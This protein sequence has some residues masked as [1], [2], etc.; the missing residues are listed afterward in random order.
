[1][2]IPAG[3]VLVALPARLIVF[4]VP[5]FVILAGIISVLDDAIPVDSARESCRQEVGFPLA[6]F[7]SPPSLKIDVLVKLNVP[8]QLFQARPLRSIP[9]SSSALAF[10][11]TG[12]VGEGFEEKEGEEPSP[13]PGNLNEGVIDEG[14][15]WSP[16]P[17]SFCPS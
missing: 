8:A 15:G 14:E 13:P 11:A 9:C 4:G 5:G 3:S 16:A 17:P 12:D 1:M 2:A 6:P 10:P 7:V